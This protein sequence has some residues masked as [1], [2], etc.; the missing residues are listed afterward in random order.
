MSNYV[1]FAGRV[2]GL[3][4]AIIFVAVGICILYAARSSGYVALITAIILIV[5]GVGLSVACFRVSDQSAIKLSQY[6]NHWAIL[7]VTLLSI[8]ISKLLWKVR[9]KWQS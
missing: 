4:L 7:P 8:V 9:E 6:G 1:S 3:L 5:V 2:Y